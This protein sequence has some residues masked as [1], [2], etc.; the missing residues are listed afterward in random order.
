M[1]NIL[2]YV[3][4]LFIPLCFFAAA[5]QEQ[6]YASLES[7][8]AAL[9]KRQ[10]KV[11]EENKRL[12]ADVS[13]LTSPERIDKTARER[14]RMRPAERDEVLRIKISSPEGAK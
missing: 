12:I 4:A 6:R 13:V 5:Y 11:I 10:Y 14:L 7:E 9:E 8:V 1:K 3:L 2:A